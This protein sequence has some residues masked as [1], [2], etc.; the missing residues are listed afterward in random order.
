MK[1]VVCPEFT[2]QLRPGIVCFLHGA[3]FSLG[4]KVLSFGRLLGDKFY[5]WEG[6]QKCSVAA[7]SV[8]TSSNSSLSKEGCI[9]R[10]YSVK[11]N[12]QTHLVLLSY[13]KL[14]LA[15]AAADAVSLC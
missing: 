7:C 5:K 12:A 15:T 8:V 11:L 13:G 14:R 1:C 9:L 4:E 3:A 6:L 10:L 2:V